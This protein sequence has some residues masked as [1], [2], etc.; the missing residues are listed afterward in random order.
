MK[1]VILAS[2]LA[3]AMMAF[4]TNIVTASD[5]VSEPTPKCGEGKCGGD[6]NDTATPRCGAGKCGGD[7]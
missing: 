2:L 6:K 1:N 5:E 7:K 3:L 4:T